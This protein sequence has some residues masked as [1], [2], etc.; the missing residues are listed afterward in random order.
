MPIF[1]IYYRNFFQQWIIAHAMT[2]SAMIIWDKWSENDVL[3]CWQWSTHKVDHVAWDVIQNI[4]FLFSLYGELIDTA[5]LL[6][7]N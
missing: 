1:H 5:D 6:A 4:L 3:N 2:I 7:Y